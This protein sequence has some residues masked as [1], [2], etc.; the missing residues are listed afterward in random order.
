MELP[1]PILG[2]DTP[3]P[4]RTLGNVTAVT[5]AAAMEDRLPRLSYMEVILTDQCNL[6]CD[7]CF[8]A[9]K[10]PS[11]HV[12]GDWEIRR[13][14]LNTGVQRYQAPSDSLLRGR[15]ATEV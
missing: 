13:R 4:P 6:R 9:D 3:Q 14:L 1:L 15:T 8:E 5:R 7:Y 2:Q 12:V 11:H 10:K